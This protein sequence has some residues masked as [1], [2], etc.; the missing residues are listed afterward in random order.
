MQVCRVRGFL[1]L[2]L[3][4]L[5]LLMVVVAMVKALPLQLLLMALQ[6]LLGLTSNCCTGVC[7]LQARIGSEISNTVRCAH[8]QGML[9]RRKTFQTYRASCRQLQRSLSPWM[10]CR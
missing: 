2:L 4:L 8:T 5:L 1:L 7:F 10:A 6:H 9:R 3:L